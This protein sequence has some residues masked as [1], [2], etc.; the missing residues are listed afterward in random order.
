MELSTALGMVAQRVLLPLLF[1]IFIFVL[2]LQFLPLGTTL[3]IGAGCS[4]CIVL[5]YTVIEHERTELSLCIQAFDYLTHQGLLFAWR[6]L[7]VAIALATVL[8]SFAL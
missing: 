5:E 2:L 7:V 1:A 8:L 6:A 4:L 3:V